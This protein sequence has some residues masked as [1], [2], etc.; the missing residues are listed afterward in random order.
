MNLFNKNL[1]YLVIQGFFNTN[2]LSF[3]QLNTLCLEK[4][5]QLGSA[6]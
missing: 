2:I 5:E 6:F 3:L 4:K 1:E